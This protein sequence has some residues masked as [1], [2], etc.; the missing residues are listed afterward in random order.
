MAKNV[1]KENKEIKG[2][3]NGHNKKYVFDNIK[4]DLGE[5][6]NLLNIKPYDKVIINIKT[7]SYR[8]N[9]LSN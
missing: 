1:K 9:K 3:I 8:W 5:Y 6:L 7:G 4:M 2:I